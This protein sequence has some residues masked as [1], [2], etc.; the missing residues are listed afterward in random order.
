LKTDRA[1]EHNLALQMPDKVKELER[2]WQEQ[3][4]SFTS[5]AKR[6]SPEQPRTPPQAKK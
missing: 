3:R 4:D 2:A 6:T 1:E 5:L